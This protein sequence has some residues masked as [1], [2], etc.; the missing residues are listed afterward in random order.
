MPLHTFKKGELGHWL[1]VVADNTN[2]EKA[3][4]YVPIP[5]EFIDALTTLRCIQRNSA[6]I[7]VVTEKGRLALHMGR[8]GEI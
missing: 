4:D 6:G 5:P 8:S 2:T 1:Q 7:L 3:Q